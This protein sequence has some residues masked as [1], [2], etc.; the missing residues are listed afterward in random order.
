ML[1]GQL[2]VAPSVGLFSAE[3]RSCHRGQIRRL[4]R[5]AFAGDGIRLCG[6]VR[7]ALF[8]SSYTGFQLALVDQCEDCLTRRR[9]GS[10][11]WSEYRATGPF[12]DIFPKIPGPRPR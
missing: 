2:N 4:G 12:G 10:E 9:C 3:R 1:N 6:W 8:S 5:A 11:A 7:A